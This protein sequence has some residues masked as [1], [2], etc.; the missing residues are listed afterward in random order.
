MVTSMG[1]VADAFWRA[2]AYCLHPRVIALSLLPL[3]L[4]SGLAIGLGYFFW[5]PAIDAVRATLDSWRLIDTMLGWFNF[6]GANE[7]RSALAPV[8]V[9]VLSLPVL[10]V[11][12]LLLVALMMTPSLVRLVT[13]RRFPQLERKQGAAWWQGAAWSLWNA[14][15]AL[16]ALLV[17]LPFWLIPPLVLILP[18]VIWGW[19]GYRVFTFDVLAEHA[20][21]VERR[22]LMREHRLPLMMLGLVTGYLG[23]APAMI[24]ALNVIAIALAPFLVLVSIWLYTLVFAFSTLWFAHY[25]LAALQELRARQGEAVKPAAAGEI[26]PLAEVLDPAAPPSPLLPPI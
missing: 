7:F 5:E 10:V 1:R 18:P 23:A 2:A 9:L 3:L 26:P 6:I 14:L 19:L 16:L 17:S 12:S 21:V 13:A 11:L 8:L 15:L 4:A 20:S 24:W 22:R 25:A